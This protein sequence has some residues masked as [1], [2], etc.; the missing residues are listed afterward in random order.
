MR[1]SFFDV[2]EDSTIVSM[3]TLR[4]AGQPARSAVTYKVLAGW[5]AVIL[6]LLYLGGGAAWH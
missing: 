5:A 1:N 6:L 4:D 2:D 3:L